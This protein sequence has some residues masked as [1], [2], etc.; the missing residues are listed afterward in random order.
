MVP[1]ATIRTRDLPLTRRLLLP[2]E[3]RGHEKG[4]MSAVP[5]R[6]APGAPGAS[7]H[8]SRSVA[9]HMHAGGPALV[10]GHT[11][12]GADDE[13]RTRGPDPGEVVLCQLS[14]IRMLRERLPASTGVAS[15]QL[16]KEPPAA[17]AADVAVQGGLGP[18]R[19]ACPAG[20]S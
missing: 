1:S 20:R 2:A 19:P 18:L 12:H 16:V 14:Y 13:S 4:S 7:L 17:N 15:L 3:L 9:T 5:T 10:R 11:R 6:A 8:V